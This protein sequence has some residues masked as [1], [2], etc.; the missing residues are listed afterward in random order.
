MLTKIDDSEIMSIQ[1][2]KKEYSSKYFI[3]V[4]TE[5]VDRAY[6]DLGYVAYTADEEREVLKIPA[7]DHERKVGGI[8]VGHS[9]E[10]FPI[11]DRVICYD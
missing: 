8:F 1:D 7:E 10:P 2:A 4:I 5:E 9:V 11:I 3:M 6:G